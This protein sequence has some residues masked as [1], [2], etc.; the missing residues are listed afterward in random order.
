MARGLS[1]LATILVIF[2]FLV[3]GG[4]LDHRVH[5]RSLQK[6]QTDDILKLV[7]AI[8]RLFNIAGTVLKKNTPHH[9]NPCP[10]G[11]EIYNF[12][13]SFLAHHYYIFSLSARC[14]GVKKKI[15]KEIMHFH[16]MTIYDHTPSQEPLPQGS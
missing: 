8:K 5:H 13:R 7:S 12:G 4:K 10:R 3:F 11:H 6:F 16:C 1:R 15:F 9:R 14:T 2:V